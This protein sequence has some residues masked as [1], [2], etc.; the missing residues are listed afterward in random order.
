MGLEDVWLALLAD[1][2]QS[3][4]RPASGLNAS[5]MDYSPTDRCFLV[6]LS[7]GA[8]HILHRTA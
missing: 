3:H 8:I 1:W 7:F 4:G 5:L 2:F 6:Y